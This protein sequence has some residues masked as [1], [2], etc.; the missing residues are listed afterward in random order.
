MAGDC[1]GERKWAKATLIYIYHHHGMALLC[2]HSVMQCDCLS[3]VKSV[4]LLC[5]AVLVAEH[6]DIW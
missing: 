3:T 5:T 6:K 4:L 1:L 2:F